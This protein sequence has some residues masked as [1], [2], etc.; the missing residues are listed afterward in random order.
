[1]K[2]EKISLPHTFPEQI[3]TYLRPF[4]TAPHIQAPVFLCWWRGYYLK[5]DQEAKL[6]KPHLPN[7]LKQ[8]LGVYFYVLPISESLTTCWLETEGKDAPRLS[9]TTKK[10]T[11][12]NDGCAQKE[13]RRERRRR[14]LH[15]ISSPA[16]SNHRLSTIKKSRQRK[17]IGK[18]AFIKK[19]C[20][21]VFHISSREE[22]C[23]MS[24]RGIY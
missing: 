13:K 4:T 14:K 9:P 7:G 2:A 5:I 11:L 24:G 3:R 20:L 18:V 22:A 19:R 16:F 1:M 6:S 10:R 23:S 12:P 15:S 21:R 8:E 17:I